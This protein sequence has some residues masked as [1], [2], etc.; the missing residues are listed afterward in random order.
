MEL[1]LNG[2][3]PFIGLQWFFVFLENRRLGVQEVLE[4][5][6]LIGF[7]TLSVMMAMISCREVEQEFFDVALTSEE[8][9]K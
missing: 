5:V 1:L 9:S 8:L 7:W 6:V 2:V 4:A 3:Q